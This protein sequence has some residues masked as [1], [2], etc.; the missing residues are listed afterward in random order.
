MNKLT[1][2]ALP[3][4]DVE[5]GGMPLLHSPYRRDSHR[6]ENRRA[7]GL[8][9]KRN[10]GYSA[11]VP[12]IAQHMQRQECDEAVFGSV[13]ASSRVEATR[14]QL[15]DRR[16]IHQDPQRLRFELR[17]EWAVEVKPVEDAVVHAV[18]PDM[19]GDGARDED[20]SDIHV[21]RLSAR[22][23]LGAENINVGR[24]L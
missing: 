5:I 18:L 15:L 3:E 12:A 10:D 17:R 13:Q 23:L 7:A 4:Q 21:R 24:D 1:F 20:I 9:V 14:F 11:N 2:P 8:G 19:G 6:R 16:V 22:L